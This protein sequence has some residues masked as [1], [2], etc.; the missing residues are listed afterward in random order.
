MLHVIFDR[1]AFHGERFDLLLT[2]QLQACCRN[3]KLSVVH[4][5]IFI[6]ETLRMY[7]NPRRRTQLR[8][9]LPFILDI[10]NGR[11]YHDTETIWRRELVLNYRNSADIFFPRSRWRRIEQR[12]KTGILTDDWS[13]WQSF[14][15]DGIETKKEIQYEI[16]REI[17][18]EGNEKRSF[19][20]ILDLILDNAGRAI[21]HRH[22]HANNNE[23]L[24]E[25]W[26]K[27]KD[28]YPFITA[29]TKGFL[30]AGYYAAREQNMPLDK[31]AQVDYGLMTYLNHADVLVSADMGFQ[32]S[33]FIALWEPHGKKLLTPEEFVTFIDSL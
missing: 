31:N 18:L 20:D 17:R 4:T 28:R 10:Y 7:G 9:Q 21:I 16:Y 24:Q 26:S 22:I 8:Q 30:F 5:P 1:S 29:F 23:A 27:N 33:A 15:W 11:A 13:E 6:D 14:I 2:S 25:K 12:I 19:K 32:R 3:R